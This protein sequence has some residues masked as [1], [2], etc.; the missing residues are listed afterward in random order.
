[1]TI[2]I[3]ESLQI[4]PLQSII[5]CPCFSIQIGHIYARHCATFRKCKAY[6][7]LIS[8]KQRNKE[9]AVWSKLLRETVQYYGLKGYDATLDQSNTETSKGPFF[10]GMSAEIAIP[11]FNIRLCGPTSTSKKIEV[12]TRFAGE[13]GIV[14]Q[15]NNNGHYHGILLRSFD[16]S[17]F[18]N[19]HG[20]DESLFFGV[21]FP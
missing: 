9:Y 21:Y 20:E 2:S 4:R 14:L 10:C 8:I 6:E 12:A 11:E 17:F 18:S 7:S 16:C 19:Y 13:K 1:M 15:L 3:M 5:S